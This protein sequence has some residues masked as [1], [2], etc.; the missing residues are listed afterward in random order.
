MT[1]TA[2]PAAPSAAEAA[3]KYAP[4]MPKAV[5]DAARAAEAAYQTDAVPDGQDGG[6]GAAPP[7]AAPEGQEP[8]PAAPQ[9][10]PQA[11]SG[12]D[13]TWEQRARSAH[14]RLETLTTENKQ[15]SSRI[16]QL[17]GLIATMQATGKAAAQEPKPETQAPTRFV[18]DEE[19][20]EYGE[21]MLDVI[22]K[23]AQEI[24]TPE[25]TALRSEVNALKNQLQGVGTVIQRQQVKGVY[26]TLE[27]AI[28]DW[29]LINRSQQFKQWA[30]E[31]EPYSGQVRN[32]LIREAFDRHEGDRVVRF[33]QGFL[34]ET[35]AL[36][37]NGQPGTSQAPAPAAGDGKIPL[38]RFAAPGR[39]G[40]GLPAAPPEK[41]TY[42]R[43]AITNHYSEHRRGLWKGRENEWKAVEQDMFLAQSEGRITP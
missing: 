6:E 1:G 10:A 43:A 28:P 31:V 7:S 30:S 5:R 22:G 17:E 11:P 38:E 42:S 25:L 2:A 26:E 15:L 3:A 27:E 4:P 24:V 18:S 35:A 36:S 12:D 19:R 8:A 39:S 23:R 20:D 40:P 32:K 13:Q 33:F 29:K 21:P 9:P 34:S 37:G 14:G 16:D 41:P